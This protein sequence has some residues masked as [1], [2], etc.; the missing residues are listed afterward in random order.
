V[1]ER[2]VEWAE[3]VSVH[4]SPISRFSCPSEGTAKRLPV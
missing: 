4:Q 1:E 3:A 2:D